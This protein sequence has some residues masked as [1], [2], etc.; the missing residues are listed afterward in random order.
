MKRRCYNP[1]RPEYSSYGGR[2]IVMC[3]QWHEFDSF[4][5]DMGPRPPGMTLDRIDNDGPYSPE[6]CRWATYTEQNRNRR[7]NRMVTVDGVRMTISEACER[8]GLHQST[9]YRRIRRG[10]AEVDWFSRPA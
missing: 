2:G 1:N 6:N 10:V 8:V 3:D 4:Y 9:V 7:D 5:S